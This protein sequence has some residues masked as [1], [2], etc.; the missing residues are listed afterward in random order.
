MPLA[1]AFIVSMGA[2]MAAGRRA[3]FLPL[4]LGL[5]FGVLLAMNGP[6]DTALGFLIVW[7]IAGVAIGVWGALVGARMR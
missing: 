2:G 7:T 6:G 4:G 1:V 5:A 3:V